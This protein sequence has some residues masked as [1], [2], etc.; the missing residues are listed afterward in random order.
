MQ[1]LEESPIIQKTWELCQAIL[2]QPDFHA[3]RRQIDTFMT[4]EDAKAQ[5]Q[6]LSEKGEYLQQKQQIGSPLTPEEI[7]DFERNREVFLNNPVARD[8][9]DAQQSMHKLQESVHQYVT[10][11]FE[12]GRVPETDDFESGSCGH[13]CGCH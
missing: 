5:Y 6:Y 1:T 8:F 9:L 7:A 13:G 10:K 2:D 4:N 11:T 3:L 12:L